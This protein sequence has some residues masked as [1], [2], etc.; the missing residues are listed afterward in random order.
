MALMLSACASVEGG[1]VP[2]VPTR[3]SE[4]SGSKAASVGAEVPPGVVQAD[5][6]LPGKLALSVS[7]RIVILQAGQSLQLGAENA[8]QPSISRDG[9]GVAYVVV[10]DGFSDLYFQRLPDGQPVRLTKNQSPLV[11]GTEA[12]VRNSVWAFNPCWL[13]GQRLAYLSDAGTLDLALW[14]VD[15][16]GK[17][18]RLRLGPPGASGLGRPACAP[19]GSRLAVSAYSGST[20]QLW[21]VDLRSGA[22]KQLTDLPAGAY[23]PAWS[24]KGDLIAFAGRNADG[25]TDIWLTTLSVPA[26]QRITDLGRARAPAWSPDGQHLAFLVEDRGIFNLWIMDITANLDGSLTVGRP[27]QV[28]SN[29]VIDANSGV[30]WGP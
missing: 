11:P 3:G 18:S 23:D 12:Y 30:S 5:V 7:G 10:G 29:L 27:R 26:P 25:S 24:P 19:D 4:V 16:S 15:L 1:T 8:F 9:N 6:R 22:W 13:D 17:R 21:L 20:T 14:Q 2:A 28:T